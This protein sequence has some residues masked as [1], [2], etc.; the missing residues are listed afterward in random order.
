P[1]RLLMLRSRAPLSETTTAKKKRKNGAADVEMRLLHAR[2]VEAVVWGMPAVNF[3]L[4][5]QA[6]VEAGGAWNQV[7]YWSRPITWKHQTLPP[8]PGAICFMPFFHLRDGPVSLE[9]PPADGGS[10]TGS[11]DDAWQCAIEDVGPA[12]ADWGKGGKYLLLPPG[13]KDEVPA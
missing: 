11:V 7:V 8:N 1:R 4:M 2:A 5:R 12:G 6:M 10:I 3:E 13:W 9:I